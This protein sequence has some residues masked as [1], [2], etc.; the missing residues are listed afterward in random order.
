MIRGIRKGKYRNRVQIIAD[1]LEIARRKPKKTQIMYQAN[2][3]YKLLCKYLN[4]IREATLIKSRKDCYLLTKKGEEFLVH[5]KK[6]SK[7]CRSLEKHLN[8]IN[9]EKI[10]LEKMLQH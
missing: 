2:L 9:C 10:V 7:Q 1:I 5:Y 3:S 8:N 4:L 6:Y